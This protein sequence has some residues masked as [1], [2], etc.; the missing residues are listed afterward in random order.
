MNAAQEGFRWG[1]L[2]NLNS[3]LGDG[4]KERKGEMKRKGHRQLFGLWPRIFQLTRVR[5]KPP[6]QRVKPLLFFIAPERKPIPITGVCF[7]Y[8]IKP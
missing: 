8:K 7:S 5:K 3:Q 2:A 1:D 4:K 6:V